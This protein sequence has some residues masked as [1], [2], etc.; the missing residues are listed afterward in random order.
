[1]RQ[2]NNYQSSM[3]GLIQIGEKEEPRTSTLINSSRFPYRYRMHQ[4]WARKPWY[5][6]R[7]YIQRYTEE[8]NTVLDPFVGSG[9]TACEALI[10]RRNVVW[11]DINPIAGLMTKVLCVS[12]INISELQSRALCIVSDLRKQV[13]HLYLT[14]CPQCGRDAEF[15][16]GIW[17]EDSLKK[18]YLRCVRCHKSE[19]KE[20][21]KQDK[22][23]A[24]TVPVGD[25]LF[26]DIY[27][28]PLPAD[29]DRNY[30][31]ELYTLRNWL[32]LETLYKLISALE[33]DEIT[34]AIKLMFCSTVARVSR[35]VFVNKYRL[36]KG[37]NPAGVWGE[38]RFWVPHESIENSV[39]YYFAQRISKIVQAKQETNMLI[40]DFYDPR[41]TF[42]G[43]VGS[44][45]KLDLPDESID[46]CF[47]DPPYGGSVK[48]LA[49]STVWNAWLNCA[50]D[51]SKEIIIDENRTLQDY[52]MMLKKS[53]GEIYRVLKPG[54]YLS[55]TFHSGDLDVWMSLLSACGESGFDLCNA[56]PEEPLKRSHNQLEMARRVTTDFVLTFRREVSSNLRG[57]DAVVD[58]V[59]SKLVE[60]EARQLIN[61][62]GQVTTAE[63]WDRVILAW[64]RKSNGH[65]QSSDLKLSMAK[66]I[67]LVRK[68]GFK[69]G[70]SVKRDYKGCSREVTIWS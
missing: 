45:L 47:T 44:G 1:M 32:A 66:L 42:R 55:V 36:S 17:E 62:K 11:R 20:A 69:E 5:V 12:P 21:D 52:E 25:P 40:G 65:P 60:D 23:L 56:V 54:R 9:V 59:V 70:I 10:L 49:L 37:V 24:A 33:P 38:K 26:K 27:W 68:L 18:V 67:S 34:E 6:V 50:I 53:M 46:Y 4:Y 2:Q 39:L 8:G 16:N 63:I 13:G 31:G 30:L 58:T 15:I 35:M 48:Y 19:L 64:L 14:T 57:S 7:D 51:T 61:E 43:F 22:T 41:S 29:S 3:N 28:H